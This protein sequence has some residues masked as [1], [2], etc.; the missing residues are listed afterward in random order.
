SARAERECSLS[1]PKLGYP[2]PVQSSASMEQPVDTD[3]LQLV[4]RP[5]AH[6]KTRHGI[7]TQRA[8]A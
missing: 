7:R 2:V 6:E 3:H 5:P 1:V 8:L 4:F